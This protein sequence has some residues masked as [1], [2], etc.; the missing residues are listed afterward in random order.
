MERGSN[1]VLEGEEKGRKSR[2]ARSVFECV[3]ESAKKCARE[4]KIS[5]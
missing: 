3:V 4:N 1:E 5:I 2:R